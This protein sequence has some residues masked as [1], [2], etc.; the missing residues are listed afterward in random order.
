MNKARHKHHT[1]TPYTNTIHTGSE[2]KWHIGRM[3]TITQQDV[4]Q[5]LK[6]D[7]SY[8]SDERN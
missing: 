2:N 6:N 8:G 3:E 7:S 4:S 1:Q 5:S